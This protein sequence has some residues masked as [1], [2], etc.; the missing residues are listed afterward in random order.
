MHA[1]RARPAVTAFAIAMDVVLMQQLL[2]CRSWLP[3]TRFTPR[4]SMLHDDRKRFK[5]QQQTVPADHDDKPEQEIGSSG[6]AN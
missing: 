3:S 4:T 6:K 5:K 1:H 2:P